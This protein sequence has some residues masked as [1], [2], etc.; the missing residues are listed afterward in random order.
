MSLASQ[1][2]LRCTNSDFEIISAALS[3]VATVGEQYRG[4]VQSLL[5]EE[6]GPLCVNASTFRPGIPGNLYY[7]YLLASGGRSFQINIVVGGIENPGTELYIEK[8]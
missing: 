5:V 4:E 3:S 2:A 8:K 6:M 1:S 7:T